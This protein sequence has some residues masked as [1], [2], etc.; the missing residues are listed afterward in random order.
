VADVAQLRVHHQPPDED[1]RRA[2]GEPC[3]ATEPPTAHDTAVQAVHKPE[4]NIHKV[5]LTK[6][7]VVKEVR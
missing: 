6:M 3:H 7:L 1:A 5:Q 2:E 4:Y